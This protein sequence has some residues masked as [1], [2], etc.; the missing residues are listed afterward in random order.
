MLRQRKYQK[1]GTQLRTIYLNSSVQNQ[2]LTKQEQKSACVPFS[3][4]TCR[5]QSS[6]EENTHPPHLSEKSGLIPGSQ[7]KLHP[8]LIEEAHANGAGPNIQHEARDEC[9]E[10]DMYLKQVM[11]TY[12]HTATLLSSRW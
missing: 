1:L 5:N 11:Y 8:P 4:F 10:A 6:L 2:F 3:S 12:W 9:A 7:H